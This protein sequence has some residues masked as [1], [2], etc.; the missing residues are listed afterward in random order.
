MKDGQAAVGLNQKG[1]SGF[2]LG[3]FKTEGAF[4]KGWIAPD[5]LR[6]LA[7]PPAPSA[8][9]AKHPI[10]LF[11]HGIGEA[12][13]SKSGA[14]QG[15]DALFA[16][17]SPPGVLASVQLPVPAAEGAS[18]RLRQ[19]LL[20][21]P[22]LPERDDSWLAHRGAINWLIGELAGKFNGDIDRLYG[23]GFSK[24]AAGIIDLASAAPVGLGEPEA[25]PFG[26][27]RR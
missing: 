4:V 5:K 23:T 3:D 14:A 19:F 22:Q 20:V 15:T 8:K 26:T 9:G 21:C 27:S 24:G 18:S 1:E 17:G 10:L 11:L 16:N 2:T 13:V 6:F 7:F 25:L 12:A